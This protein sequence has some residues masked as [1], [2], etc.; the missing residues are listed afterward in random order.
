MKHPIH[1]C[2]SRRCGSRLPNKIDRERRISEA[3]VGALGRPLQWLAPQR[4]NID[5]RV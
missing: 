4:R 1:L 5:G 2:S 3:G